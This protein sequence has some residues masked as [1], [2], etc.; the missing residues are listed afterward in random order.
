MTIEHT[1]SIIKPD[2]IE[3]QLIGEIITRIEKADLSII[4]AKMIH[5]TKEQA[6]NFYII[7]KEKSFYRDLVKFMTSDPILVM[8]LEG[9]NAIQKYREVMGATN[10]EEAAPNTI[11]ANFAES[12]RRNAVH[13]SDGP[14]TARNEITFFF[15]PE[16][17]FTDIHYA[18]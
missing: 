14:E 11:R 8:V 12:I 15:T 1:L 18:K 5:L 13:G 4:A 17:I 9:E 2:E 3:K 10:P 7:H 6:Q 16:E